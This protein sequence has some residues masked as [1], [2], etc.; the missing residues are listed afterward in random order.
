MSLDRVLN[1]ALRDLP[2]GEK[3]RLTTEM[4]GRRLDI[5]LRWLEGPVADINVT[6]IE[7]NNPVPIR[8]LTSSEM[9]TCLEIRQELKSK[10]YKVIGV[11]GPSIDA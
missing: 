7:G 5:I 4:N 2:K 11:L 6:Q 1:D 3:I 10:G 8:E 9:K